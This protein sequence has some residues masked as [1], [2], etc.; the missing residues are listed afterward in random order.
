MRI[1]MRL[2]AVLAVAAIGLSACGGS[3]GGSA[4]L[5]GS[6]TSSGSRAA[7]SVVTL[8][9]YH[10][11]PTK[12]AVAGISS[13]GFMAVQMQVAYSD[14]F[15]DVAVYAGGPF[16]CAQDSLTTAENT[17]QYAVSS[18]LS[19][20]ESYTDS[21]SG[22]GIAAKTNIASQKAYLWSGTSDETVNQKT[23]NDLNSYETHY[24]ANVI[25]YDNSYA[26][27]HGWE[28][29]YGEVACGTTASPYMID[30][31]N[32]DSE[33]VWLSSFFGT[34]NPKNTGT[35]TGSLINFSQTPYG[36][37]AND[38]DTNGYLFVPASCAAGSTCALV[39]ALDGCVQEQSA[40][41][42]KFVTEAG[43]DQWADTNNIIVMYPYQTSSTT[44]S[45][46]NGCWDWW[47]Y[48]NS[49]YALRSGIQMKAIY[50]MVE[51]VMSGGAGS[52]P[53]PSPT[54]TATA[55]PTATP[56]AGPTGTPTAKPT[57]TPTAAPTATP[58]ASPTTA[59]FTSVAAEDGYFFQSTTDGTADSTGTVMKVGKDTTNT[60]QEILV[61]FDT[62]S[63]PA[64][65][66][67]TAATLTLIKADY[68]YYGG[69]L[70]NLYADVN[71]GCLS[72]GCTVTDADYGA[73]VTAANAATMSIPA[74]TQGLPSTGT[75]N[76]AGLAAI[77][78]GGP[79][80]AI[81]VHFATQN[82]TDYGIDQLDFNSSNAAT[83]RPTLSVTY[84]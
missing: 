65:A 57:A 60:N 80:T 74:Q 41:G 33:Q 73:T 69:A 84:H 31:S 56:T 24:G 11:D 40:I 79:R 46:P 22:S 12:V 9:A 58:S 67:I 54:P 83:G 6:G 63:I 19:A 55:R 61:S 1:H 7:Q 20:A 71:N 77:S 82:N 78:K 14:I 16:Y 37:G 62:S 52:T 75:L 50:Q 66:T 5:P 47:G 72:P 3:S 21:Q 64:G 2:A 13:G 23:M 27:G 43:I 49:S 35:L 68:N 28:S 53:T 36:G 34:L 42:T 17:C 25:K 15:K 10:I 81:R 76:A 29:P 39:V 18:S 32:Y 4:A 44:P 59:S 70:G 51:Q 8:G 48:T 26:A 30:C 38:L 45:N